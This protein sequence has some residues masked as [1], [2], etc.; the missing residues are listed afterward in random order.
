MKIMLSYSIFLLLSLALLLE[1]H[2]PA[3]HAVT[4]IFWIFVVIYFMREVLKDNY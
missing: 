1:Y 4:L 2:K 3:L